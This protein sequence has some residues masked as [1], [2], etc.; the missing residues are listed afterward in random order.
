MLKEVGSVEGGA[1][2]TISYYSAPSIHS[3][4]I[5]PSLTLLKNTITDS[6]AP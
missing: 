2:Q 1:S 6:T 5:I 3:P 4:E